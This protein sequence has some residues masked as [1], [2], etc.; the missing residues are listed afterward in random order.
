MAPIPWLSCQNGYLQLAKLQIARYIIICVM[1]QCLDKVSPPN[2]QI[3]IALEY[4]M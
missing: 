2:H 3:P 4:M 1:D